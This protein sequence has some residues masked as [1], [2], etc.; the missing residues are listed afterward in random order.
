MTVARAE[1]GVMQSGT[2]NSAYEL[3]MGDVEKTRKTV[4]RP[5]SP[6]EEHDKQRTIQSPSQE[7]E[8]SPMLPVENTEK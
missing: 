7:A 1:S 6:V 5:P 3:T 4:K 8:R 2:A